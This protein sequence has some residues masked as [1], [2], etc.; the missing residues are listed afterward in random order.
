MQ[1]NHRTLFQWQPDEVILRQRMRLSDRRWRQP[2]SARTSSAGTGPGPGR[3]ALDRAF[4]QFLDL[5]AS[6]SGAAARLR[7][8]DPRGLKLLTVLVL[9][10]MVGL[11]AAMARP[12]ERDPAAVASLA[13][14]AETAPAPAEAPPPAAEAAA[15]PPVLMAAAMEPAAPDFSVVSKLIVERAADEA[16]VAEPQAAP[17]PVLPTN[18]AALPL[19]SARGGRSALDARGAEAE[20]EVE[21]GDATS[22]TRKERSKEQAKPR[23]RSR[24]ASRRRSR[25]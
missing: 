7:A 4:D 21:A 18:Y 11:A 14:P 19:P 24:T 20:D 1:P 8:A 23:S 3:A 6:G 5:A 2:G 25:R 16:A 12:G 22:A 10:G 13:A 9:A 15:P 17:P